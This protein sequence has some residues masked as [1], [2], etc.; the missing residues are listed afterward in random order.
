MNSFNNLMFLSPHCSHADALVTW[1]ELKYSEAV[2]VWDCC[3]RV[4]YNMFRLEFGS[5]NEKQGNAFLCTNFYSRIKWTIKQLFFLLRS[6]EFCWGFE[7]RKFN[8]HSR[9]NNLQWT[10]KQWLLFSSFCW[11][12]ENRIGYNF[13]TKQTLRYL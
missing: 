11:G 5:R 4:L 8:F 6:N 10:I 3:Q 13:K 1:F 7:N 9:R 2:Q 12:F